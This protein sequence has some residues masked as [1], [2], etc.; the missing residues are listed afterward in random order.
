MPDLRRQAVAVVDLQLG[1]VGGVAGG[2]VEAPAGLRVEQRSVRLQPP[3]LTAGGATVPELDLAEV[4]RAVGDNV[5][6]LAEGPYGA[7]RFE[8]PLLAGRDAA[9][10]ELHRVAV[11]RGIRVDV[12]AMGGRAGAGDGAG[13]AGRDVRTKAHLALAV[14]QVGDGEVEQAVA[15]DREQD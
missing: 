4:G 11:G 8:R 3:L 10:V 6:A 2:V 13:R 7:V 14:A 9:G 5:E 1:A 12:N 15:G